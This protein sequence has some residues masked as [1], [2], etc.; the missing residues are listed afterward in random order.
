IGTNNN[1]LS[2]LIPRRQ[3]RTLRTNTVAHRMFQLLGHTEVLLIPQYVHTYV[4]T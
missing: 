3:T 2:Q 1:N 4:C